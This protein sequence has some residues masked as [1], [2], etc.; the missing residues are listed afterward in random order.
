MNKIKSIALFLGAMAMS[1]AVHAIDLENVSSGAVVLGEW[2]SNFSA[3]KA[4]ADSKGIPMLLFWSSPGC[5]KCN[6]LKKG[7]NENSQFVQY[8]KSLGI[9]MAFSEGD[10]TSKAFARNPSGHYPYLRIY[11]PAGG[12]DVKFSGRMGEIGASGGTVEEQ[13]MN[14]MKSAL[15]AWKGGSGTGGGNVTPGR[16]SE[17]TT[18]VIGAEWNKSRKINAS[19]WDAD[20]RVAGMVI[21][22][23]GKINKKTKKS[24]IKVQIYNK[25]GKTKTIDSEYFAVNT[26]TAV[27]LS[28]KWGV[29]KLQIKGAQVTGTYTFDGVNYEVKANEP[30][31][32]LTDGNYVFGLDLSKRA[33]T[34]CGGLNLVDGNAYLPLQQKVT[35]S[36]SKFKVARKGT[37]R[38]DRKTGKFTMNS[39]E[40]PSG[41]KF[42]Y[43]KTR[44]Y[45]KGTFTVYGNKG[46]S[47]KKFTAKFGGFMVGT[48]GAGDVTIKGTTGVY[49]FDIVINQ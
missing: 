10:G 28:S 23:A 33:L 1:L 30:G 11:W 47:A 32:E 41:I 18:P 12:V 31:G 8:R 15:A 19:Y 5:A 26:P 4:M 17:S 2:N 16:S 24:K 40:N 49:P 29:V 46:R 48:E 45:V 37:L 3:C 9:I 20:G 27:N 43:N 38:Y 36:R 25:E 44:G 7:C 6:K 42:S 14:R 34:Q 39:M 21:V 13:L 35:V 22:S